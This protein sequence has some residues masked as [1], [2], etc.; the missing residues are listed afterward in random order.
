[1]HNKLRRWQEDAIT[2]AMSWF[3]AN[4]G[5][6]AQ[7]FLINAAPGAGKTICS[8]ALAQQLIEKGLIDRVIV[9]APRIQ[10][11]KQW[12][13]DFKALT[14]RHMGKVEASATF[15]SS[16]GFDLCLTWNSVEGLEPELQAI[17]SSHKVLVICDEHHHAAVDAVWGSATS[18]AFNNAAYRLLLTGTPMRSDGEAS[19]WL[20]H[21]SRGRIDQPADG[22]YTLSYGEAVEIGYC[23]PITFHRHQ[24]EFHVD[25]AGE[26][27]VVR[28]DQEAVFSDEVARVPN[29][30][31][32]LDFYRLTTTP[33][34]ESDGLTPK[35]GS[36]Q[37]SMVAE[38]SAKLDEIRNEMPNAGGL[39][40]AQ[41]IEWAEIFAKLIERTE[42]ERP[43]V[44]HSQSTNSD[45]L[46]DAFRASDKR[47]IVSVNMISEGVDIKRLR[48]LVYLPYAQTELAFRQAVG[49]VVRSMGADDMSRAYMVMPAYNTFE[50]YARR[51]E[52]E[53]PASASLQ[54]SK[55]TTKV[56][57]SCEGENALENSTCDFC[58][59]EFPARRPPAVACRECETLNPVQAKICMGCGA[60]MEA[61]I[62]MSLKEA[63]RSGAIV[64]GLDLTEEE[65]QEAERIAPSVKRAL[66]ASGDETLIS[67]VKRLPP[68][69]FVRLRNIMG[70]GA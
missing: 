25:I 55:R 48:V 64:R 3:Y 45:S 53:M 49:R 16:L 10:V 9:I 22:T 8:I 51:V 24:G 17:C 11:V 28:G 32:M 42:G 29:I 4:T 54:Q 2:K 14:G 69:S 41:S 58:G 6:A 63:L 27:V 59:Y 61:V 66:L 62:D 31:Q 65:V 34:Y 38:A 70:G 1:M 44:V 5:S 43:F 36:Y 12:G 35:F 26:T 46:I 37:E 33:Q 7:R 56:C 67:V 18:S 52:G 21:D 57:P 15:L 47:W 68:E 23:R 30:A 20:A 50:Q 39:V 40:I 60:S 13:D 19:I